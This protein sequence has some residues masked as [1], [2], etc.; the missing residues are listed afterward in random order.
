MLK[1]EKPAV[2]HFY[3]RERSSSHSD[4]PC[5][6]VLSVA[7]FLSF[8]CLFPLCSGFILEVFPL[9]VYPTV[10]IFRELTSENIPY[11][12]EYQLYQHYEGSGGTGRHIEQHRAVCAQ[13]GLTTVGHSTHPG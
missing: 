7:G 5:A 13:S 1:C 3:H 8:P 4:I 9:R 11:V 6:G 2:L 12:P 10:L